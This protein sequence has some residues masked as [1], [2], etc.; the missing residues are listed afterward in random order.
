MAVKGINAGG[1]LCDKVKVLQ[2]LDIPVQ[3][4]VGFVMDYQVWSGGTLLF[5]C[6]SPMT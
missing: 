1:D 3:E 5:H 4:L 2:N 6:I